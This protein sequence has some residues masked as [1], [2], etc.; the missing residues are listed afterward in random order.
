[1]TSA[2]NKELLQVTVEK[3]KLKT[4]LGHIKELTM[5]FPRGDFCSFQIDLNTAR[6]YMW[7]ILRLLF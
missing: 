5:D 2:L 4:I 1:M 6:T 7:N 3:E